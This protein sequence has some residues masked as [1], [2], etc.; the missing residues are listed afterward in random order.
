[1]KALDIMERP[2]PTVSPETTVL[3]TVRLMLEHKVSGVAVVD[4]SGNLVGMITEGDLLRRSELGTERKVTGFAA[5][6]AGTTKLAEDF[7]RAHSQK[8]G[9]V[10]TEGPV[11]IEEE[12]GIEGIVELIEGRHLHLVPVVRQ[13]FLIGMIDRPCLLRALI[14]RAEAP[15]D[16][17]VDDDS[18]RTA[19]LALYGR[20]AWAPLSQVDVIVRNGNVEL[21]GNVTDPTKRK[22]LVVAA[23]AIPGVKSVKDRLSLKQSGKAKN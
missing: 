15:E 20:E 8:I 18:I 21:R 10:M 23:E 11:A 4:S 2:G 6:Q 17:P 5:V 9:D 22:A 14:R 12:T 16:M 1:M 3:D 19:L 13:G 7:V